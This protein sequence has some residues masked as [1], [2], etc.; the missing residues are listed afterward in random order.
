MSILLFFKAHNNDVN[1]IISHENEK[2][3]APRQ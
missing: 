3:K 1:N 2:S